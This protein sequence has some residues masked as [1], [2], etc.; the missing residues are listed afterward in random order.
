M[1]LAIERNELKTA[2]ETFTEVSAALEASYRDLE[3][4]VARLHGELARARRDRVRQEAERERMASRHHELL[5]ALPG[6]VLE[7]DSHGIVRAANPAAEELL[8]TPPEGRAWADLSEAAGDLPVGRE[9]VLPSG[10]RV[11]VAR[12]ELTGG[13]AIVLLTDVTEAT[14]VRDL[15]ARHQRLSTLG[16][17]AARLAHDVRTPLAAALLY[18]S[19][20]GQE[21]LA[22]GDRREIAGKVVG[23]LR[24]LEGLVADMLAFARGAGAN[25]VRCDVGALLES[26]AQSLVPRLTDRA[27]VTIRTLAPGLAVRGNPEALV[28]AILNLANNALDA[29]GPDARVEIEAREV[30][31]R[32]EIR[33]RD[34]G[35]GVPEG[36]HDRIFEPFF[37]TRTG[38]TG[39]GLA[40]VRTVALAHGGAVELEPAPEGACFCL[41]LAAH[42][43]DA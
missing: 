26:V 13:G 6:G 39:L 28:G 12:R 21:E 9:T 19:R 25:L 30:G 4:E 31:G 29:A 1:A 5:S 15:L 34:N 43:N 35:P 11:G 33:V 37:T 20:L 17:M 24:H 14:L 41:R 18:A 3:R 32:A 2:F 38:G 16:E 23:R 10:R 36:M 22:D 27:R 8:G 42:G 40:V 7:L